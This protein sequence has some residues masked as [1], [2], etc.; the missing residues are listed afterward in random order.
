[1]RFDLARPCDNCPFR[2]DRDAFLSKERA[3]EIADALLPYPGKDQTF[4]CHKTLGYDEEAEETTVR[5]KSQ[6]C[7]GAMIVL[8]KMGKPNQMMQISERLHFRDPA[9]LDMSSPVFDTMGDFVDH[10]ANMRGARAMSR[11]DCYV[12]SKSL[13]TYRVWV[14]EQIQRWASMCRM[15]VGPEGLTPMQGLQFDKWLEAST[16]AGAPSVLR[17][18]KDVK[19]GR[20]GTPV[21]P[22]SPPKPL[23]KDR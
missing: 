20:Q 1:M 14:D 22:V 3:A 7:A 2:T 9:K 13:K 6:H 8:E 11:H 21:K 5:P 15:K 17:K 12:R 16:P 18:A 10:H 23:T 19:T 4:A